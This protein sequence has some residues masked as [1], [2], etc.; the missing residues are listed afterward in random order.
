MLAGKQPS[1]CMHLGAKNVSLQR[2]VKLQDGTVGLAIRVPL[3]KRAYT[4]HG[5]D[6]DDTR[7]WF[8][9]KRVAG[10]GGGGG[11]DIV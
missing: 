2:D 10:G 4:L 8:E 3:E 1:G 9:G 6:E 7:A 5:I 11:A